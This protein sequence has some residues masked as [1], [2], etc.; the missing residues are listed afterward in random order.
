MSYLDFCEE[1]GFVLL[2]IEIE[3]CLGE[4]C[5]DCCEEHHHEEDKHCNN[6]GCPHNCNVD[7]RLT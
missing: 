3:H 6:V 1:C 2:D 7:K 5:F 4:T